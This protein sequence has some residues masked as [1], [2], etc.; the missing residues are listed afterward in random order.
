MKT[1]SDI[2]LFK[3]SLLCCIISFFWKVTLTETIFLYHIKWYKVR[4]VIVYL[5]Q[6]DIRWEV[7]NITVQGKIHFNPCIEDEH[8]VLYKT[9]HKWLDENMSLS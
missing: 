2:L 1:N 4:E 5:S 9:F 3:K 6:N 8:T 7:L